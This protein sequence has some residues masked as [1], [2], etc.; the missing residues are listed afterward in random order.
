MAGKK[1]E[2]AK[3]KS[4]LH[5]R[6]K[7]RSRY[8]FEPLIAACPDLEPFVHLNKYQDLSIDFFDAK[9]V[10]MLNTALL[11]HHYRL[12]F[13]DIPSEYL[14]PPIPGRADYIHNVAD[15]LFRNH[16]HM[17]K[18]E[19]VKNNH[20]RCLDVGVG[21]NCIYPIIGVSEYGWEFVGA[22]VDS[23]AIA[24][25]QDIVDKNTTLSAHIELRL[26]P[27][28]RDF[29]T[30]IIK[31]GELFDLTVCNPP[32]HGSLEEA[33]RGTRRKL[34]NLKGEK[35][36][37]PDLNFSGQ[38]NELWYEGGELKF[39]KDMIYQSR[40]HK[41]SCLWFST[42]IS[43]ESN[44]PSIHKLLEKVEAKEVGTL[45]MGQGNKIS[46]VVIWTFMSKSKQQEWIKN[47]WKVD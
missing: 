36:V 20:I 45:P 28:S 34:K 37:Q 9:A 22:D 18:D 23:K 1:K 5:P 21:A 24:I 29:F 42:L 30:G 33:Q 31:E 38:S 47:R 25:A 19:I 8:D 11:L 41:D 14:C 17:L 4:K 6:S 12:D 16:P 40:Q 27:S 39:L 43:K 7:H 3:I 46:R 35:K 10:K 15:V 13:W 2:H 32:F 44:V 26:Q